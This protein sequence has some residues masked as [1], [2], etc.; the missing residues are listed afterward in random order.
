[1]ASVESMIIATTIRTTRN[2]ERIVAAILSV[3]VQFAGRFFPLIYAKIGTLDATIFTTL[4]RRAQRPTIARVAN[5]ADANCCWSR[6][7][8]EASLAFFRF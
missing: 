4:N 7:A 5:N 2:S 6:E 8:R 1:M 3:G